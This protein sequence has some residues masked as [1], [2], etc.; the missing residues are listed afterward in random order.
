MFQPHPSAALI[1]A[2][3][4]KPYQGVAPADA[5]YLFIGLDANY[6]ADIEQSAVFPRMLDY[7][8]DGAAFWRS[9]GVHHP[10]LLPGYSGDGRKYHATFAQIGFRPDH[11]SAVS[12]IELVDVPTFGQ[13]KLSLGDLN[14]D[15]L[16][17]LNDAILGGAAKH[18]F[19]PDRVGRLMHAS[20]RFPWMP[21]APT[22]EGAPLRIWHR[23][24]A[25]TVW[26]HYHLSVYGKFERVK[27][28]QIAAMR[29]L[30]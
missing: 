25:K 27:R 1:R 13:S 22:D 20:G 21:K 26:W 28:E 7:L 12:F 3:A 18:V 23:S 14:G 15:H 10:F 17:R 5:T 30:I 24:D 11:A 16:A 2:F 9:A 4:L 29:A 19:V 8:A 6:A